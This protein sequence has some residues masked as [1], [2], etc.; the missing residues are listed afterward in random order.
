M[1]TKREIAATLREQ[2]GNTMSQSQVQ[3]FL[4]C[5]DHQI[6]EYLKDVPFMRTARKKTFL[7][8]DVARRLYE[9]QETAC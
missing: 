2:Y 4:G 3:A 7:V 8:I 9:M 1:A 5:G 6:A